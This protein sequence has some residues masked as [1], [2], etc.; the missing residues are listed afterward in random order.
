MNITIKKCIL[1]DLHLL[2]AL[3]IETFDETFKDQNSPE[4]MKAYLD[5]A[6]SVEKLEQE[7][8]CP[9][10]A[11]FFTMVN[12]EPAGYLKLNIN[13]A[14]SDEMGADALEIERIYI[15]SRYHGQGLGKHLI[16]H[17][18]VNA[19]RHNK[20]RVWL[21]VWENNGPAIGFYE[22]MGFVRTGTHIFQ[23][24]DEAQTDLIMEKVL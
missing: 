21:G 13:E 23:M 15:S 16:N 11:F 12:G 24:G 17:A 18:L 20:G 3:S 9:G 1:D 10:S 2:Q 4:V 5:K 7:L 6:F 19:A 8:A 14:Q 22:K